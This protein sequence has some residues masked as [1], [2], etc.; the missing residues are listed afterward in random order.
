MFTITLMF[1]NDNAF[2][3]KDNVFTVEQITN[4]IR[5]SLEGSFSNIIVKGEVS[6]YKLSTTGHAYFTLKDNFAQ[7]SVALFKGTL[8]A[9]N[10]IPKD[11]MMIQI[12]GKISVYPQRGNYQLVVKY[13]EQID[14]TGKIMKMIEE[15]KRKLYELGYFSPEHKKKLPQFAKTIGIITSPTGAAIRDILQVTKRRNDS[16]NIIIYPAVV[17]GSEAAPSIERMI[18][19]A[20]RYKMCDVLIVGRGGGGLEDLL[21]L[22]EE[23]VVKLVVLSNIEP[24]S[25]TLAVFQLLT[26]SVVSFR[27]L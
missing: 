13:M 14:D 2:N 8:A 15:R 9:S 1:E 10:F 26:S 11:G 12:W 23:N 24:I 16:V 4:L 7:I 6:N 17:Q 21:P 19:L 3:E 27:A 20:N 22:S 5:T 25:V 18:R